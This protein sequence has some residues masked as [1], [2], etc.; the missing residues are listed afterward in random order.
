MNK[1]INEPSK[2]WTTFVRIGRIAGSA[3]LGTMLLLS[4]VA[5]DCD[6]DNQSQSV[7]IHYVQ[8][9][10]SDLYDTDPTGSSHTTTNGGNAVYYIT[11]IQNPSNGKMFNF[12]PERL[13][14]YNQ[15]SGSRN[16]AWSQSWAYS[17][18]EALGSLAAQ[19]TTIDPGITR[20]A[21]GCIAVPIGSDPIG[22][23]HYS[24]RYDNKPDN[25]SIILLE[26]SGDS[27]P[28]VPLSPDELKKQCLKQ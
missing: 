8:K 14:Y 26:D 28:N 7:I 27:I 21:I 18:L 25:D 11:E 17:A 16:N 19:S 9:V 6:S 4:S 20:T 3:S 1:Y 10:N 15:S 2:S 22:M 23:Y 13:Y 5:A 24:L 12:E